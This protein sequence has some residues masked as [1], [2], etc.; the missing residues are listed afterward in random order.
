MTKNKIIPKEH[1]IL[2][3]VIDKIA[4]DHKMSVSALAIATGL[5]PTAFNKS[6]RMKGE[7][8]RMPTLTT[9]LALM[10]VVGINWF[11]WADVWYNIEQNK[12]TQ[13]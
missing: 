3:G 9:I 13:K 4:K 2:W 12:K 6:K 11:D 7:I 10:R 1:E 5:D 8:Y